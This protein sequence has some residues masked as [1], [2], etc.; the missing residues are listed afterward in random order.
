[1]CTVR[2]VSGAYAEY[3]TAED[4]F[5]THL[6]D[7]LSFAQGAAIGA[8]YYTAVKALHIRS[9]LLYYKLV[10]SPMWKLERHFQIH[11]FCFGHISKL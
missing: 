1:M 2:S 3:A 8:P 7:Q 5:V 10:N 9:V 6:S 11:G 4:K